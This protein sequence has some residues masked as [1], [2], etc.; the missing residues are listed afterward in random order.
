M[1]SLTEKLCFTVMV[2]DFLHFSYA[3]EKSERNFKSYCATEFGIDIDYLFLIPDVEERFLKSFV[4]AFEIVNREI[5]F[6]FGSVKPV[7]THFLNSEQGVVPSFRPGEL[8]NGKVNYPDSALL[9]CDEIVSKSM[10]AVKELLLNSCSF[11][12]LFITLENYCTY[13]ILAQIIIRFQLA[14]DSKIKITFKR[15]QIV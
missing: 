14:N 5:P 6:C 9:N 1:K 3:Y 2:N 11:E 15:S 10:T 8:F 4:T 13:L 12:S 7:M